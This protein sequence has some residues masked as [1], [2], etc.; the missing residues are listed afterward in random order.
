MIPNKPNIFECDPVEL[1]QDILSLKIGEELICGG[2]PGD[3]VSF[4]KTDHS[5]VCDEVYWDTSNIVEIEIDEEKII[6]LIKELQSHT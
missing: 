3:C 4:T 2:N 1:A 6:S 5:I